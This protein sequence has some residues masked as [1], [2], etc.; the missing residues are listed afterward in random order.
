[1]EVNGDLNPSQ[2]VESVY[3]ATVRTD[4]ACACERAFERDGSGS[5]GKLWR[6]RCKGEREMGV[7]LL[8]GPGRGR[9]QVGR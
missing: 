6:L 4:G 2:L 9:D 5:A 1:M 7:P 8:S 3:G